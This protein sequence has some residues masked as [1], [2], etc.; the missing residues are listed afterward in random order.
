M[1]YIRLRRTECRVKDEDEDVLLLSEDADQ[2][3]MDEAE[4]LVQ[5]SRSRGKSLEQGRKEQLGS[6]S[7]SQL[8]WL[9]GSSWSSCMEVE[10]SC[11]DGP[12]HGDS[13]GNCLGS[14]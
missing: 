12:H 10:R 13:H 7:S 3:A 1:S 9:E 2:E 11:H 4:Q 6:W 14:C 5:V 8:L